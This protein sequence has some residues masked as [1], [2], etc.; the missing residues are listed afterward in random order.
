MSKAIKA[1]VKEVRWVTTAKGLVKPLVVLDKMYKRYNVE[2]DTLA[3]DNAI[4]VDK[5]N[6][7]TDEIVDITVDKKNGKLKIKACTGRSK[8]LIPAK[9]NV[10]G[11]QLARYG[12]DHLICENDTCGAKSRTPILKLVKCAFGSDKVDVKDI[13][14]YINNFPINSDKSLFSMASIFDFLQMFYDAGP[15]DTNHRDELLK[16]AYKESYDAVKLIESR[17]N[18]YLQEGVTNK[19]LWYIA[20]IRGIDFTRIDELLKIN[21]LSTSRVSF[22]EQVMATG[23][24]AS[25]KQSIII[26]KK[27]IYQLLKF[28]NALK[29]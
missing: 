10:C 5:F 11:S 3:L 22:E 20:T 16:T 29:K 18:S 12:Q 13:Y 28:F 25:V 19:D 7:K 4:T 8:P 26:N 15:K 24:N 23:L 6:I 27:Y 21:F 9:C 1:N 17:V 2:F 14:T